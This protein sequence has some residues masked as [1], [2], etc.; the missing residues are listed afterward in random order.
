MNASSTT[1]AIHTMNGDGYMMNVTNG[2]V[3]EKL[4]KNMTMKMNELF[5]TLVLNLVFSKYK[6]GF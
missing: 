3:I 2:Y 6:Y 5:L 1:I 4:Q